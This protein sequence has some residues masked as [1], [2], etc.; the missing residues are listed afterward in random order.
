MTEDTEKFLKR[1]RP[2]KLIPFPNGEHS[3]I[4]GMVIFKDELYVATEQG[5]FKLVG[6]AL[7]RVMFVQP[8]EGAIVKEE[9]ETEGVDNC[10]MC[11]AELRTK[12]S[13]V[14]CPNEECG[15]TYCY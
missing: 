7:E 12:F 10:P 15:Y 13:G 6:K 4:V 3:R 14:K 8:D 2:G 1:P 11:G 5:V 9:E